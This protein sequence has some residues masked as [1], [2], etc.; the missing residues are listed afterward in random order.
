M[1]FPESGSVAFALIPIRRFF[2]FSLRSTLQWRY[3]PPNRHA[4]LRGLMFL[5]L[6][7]L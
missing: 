1:G 7:A 3:A 2:M 5:Y 4:F 6:F